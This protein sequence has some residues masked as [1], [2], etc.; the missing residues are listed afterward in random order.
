RL[1]PLPPQPVP[2]PPLRNFESAH[3]VECFSFESFETHLPN[4]LALLA[5]VP[6]LSLNASKPISARSALHFFAAFFSASVASSSSDCCVWPA[7]HLPSPLLPYFALYA[8]R[9]AARSALH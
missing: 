6:Y 3:D 4:A 1:F 7:T 5:F 8:A 2:P 9:S